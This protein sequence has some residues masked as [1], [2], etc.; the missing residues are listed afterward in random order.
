MYLGTL[1]STDTSVRIHFELCPLARPFTL[2]GSRRQEL[3]EPVNLQHSKVEILP[4]TLL[5]FNT[6][7]GL[8]ILALVA[9]LGLIDFLSSDTLLSESNS[10]V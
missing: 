9:L 6:D 1:H 2:S 8:I 3:L 10:S 7:R 4:S 5:A